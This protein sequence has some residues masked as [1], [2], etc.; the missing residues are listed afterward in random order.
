MNTQTFFVV[1]KSRFFS[2]GL[3]SGKITMPESIRESDD[4]DLR[5]NGFLIAV[6]RVIWW[7]K[8]AFSALS[9]PVVILTAMASGS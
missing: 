8:P 6:N 9:S 3:S 4:L 7:R 2:L 1:S 5:C